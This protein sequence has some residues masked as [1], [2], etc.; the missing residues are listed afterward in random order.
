[1]NKKVNIK[2]TLV[3][4]IKKA[5]TEKGWRQ[6]ELAAKSGVP[7][8]VLSRLLAGSVNIKV[9]SIH[10]ILSALDPLNE[11]KKEQN[12]IDSCSGK[13]S[14]KDLFLINRIIEIL[15]YNNKYSDALRENIEIFYTACGSNPKKTHD[16]RMAAKSGSK[17]AAPKKAAQ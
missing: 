4:L 1:M 17:T 9:D 14:L 3:D 6:L 16:P 12:F 2:N 10:K 5:M 13:V 8:P 11:E 7:Q 15:N